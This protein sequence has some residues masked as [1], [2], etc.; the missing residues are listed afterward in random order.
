[1]V[2][3]IASD[4]PLLYDDDDRDHVNAYFDAHIGDTLWFTPNLINVLASYYISQGY[5]PLLERSFKITYKPEIVDEETGKVI[6]D[7]SY[8]VVPLEK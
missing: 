4:A 8:E 7:S 2:I 6:L 5:S 1:M 3:I